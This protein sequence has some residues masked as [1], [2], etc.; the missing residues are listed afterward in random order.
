MD[1]L[2]LRSTYPEPEGQPARCG[3]VIALGRVLDG[4]QYN[5][6]E[7]DFANE[8]SNCGEY[9][10]LARRRP[11]VRT[12]LC[13]T[14][15]DEAVSLLFGDTHWPS[16]VAA[17]PDT[18]SVLETFARE[19]CLP[20]IMAHAATR[21]S[22]GSVALLVEAHDRALTVQVLDTAYL[23]P[24]W[25]ANGTLQRVTERYE[26]KGRD[27][28]AQGYA[29]D[30]TAMEVRYWYQRAWTANDIEVMQ[31]HRIEDGAQPVKDE[32]R[33]HWHG[34]G[35][36]PIVW[37]RNLA[38]PTTHDIDGPCTFERAIDTVIEVDYL[39]S[40][41]GRALKYTSDPTLVINAGEGGD[42]PK[43]ARVGGSASALELP[44][45]GD[46][47]LLEI[48]GNSTGALLEH[49]RE[50]RALVLEQ[51]HGNRA[52]AD[53][54]AAAQS[55]RAMEM[56]CQSLIWLADALRQSYGDGGLLPLYRMVCAFS[57]AIAGGVVIGGEDRSRLD[58]AGLDLRWPAWF[59]PTSVELLQIAQG[60]VTA[61]KGGLMSE[62]TA[63]EL[64]AARVGITDA[65]A[66]WERVKAE[67]KAR[68]PENAQNV[69]RDANTGLTLS[70]QVEA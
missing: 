55:G 7:H 67:I 70:H 33:S 10:P 49:Y 23:T 68:P 52:H 35:F 30:K 36:V 41:G 61:V 54:I 48:N 17:T 64:Y 62:Q 43:P 53:R 18:A 39:L 26:V 15:V 44:P 57:S 47:K 6:L 13:R 31:P 51:L 56:M 69:H 28:A 34:L 38:P 21:G 2:S 42:E 16:V 9:I 59:P 29:I 3:R 14:V 5:G 65:A 25:A 50:L 32:G 58:P 4:T 1:W 45:K 24:E 60:L 27:L 66:E 19:A 11:S 8:N 22:V 63:C 20:A 37:I 46:A 12:N 40:Q